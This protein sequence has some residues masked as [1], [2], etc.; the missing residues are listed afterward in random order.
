MPTGTRGVPQHKV[1]PFRTLQLAFNHDQFV[2]F[3]GHKRTSI[4]QNHLHAFKLIRCAARRK[5]C[6][7]GK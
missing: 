7:N 1:T 6:K 5:Q 3:D 2:W 4:R